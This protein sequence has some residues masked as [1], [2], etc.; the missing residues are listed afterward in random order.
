MADEIV[1]FSLDPNRNADGS[2][3]V[4]VV[5]QVMTD[6]NATGGRDF[7]SDD[8]TQLPKGNL[9]ITGRY[10][11][12]TSNMGG[13]R[14]DAFL[15]KVPYQWF[16]QQVSVAESD[17]GRSQ[18]HPEPDL[19]SSV[20]SA[21]M[22]ADGHSR[23]NSHVRPNRPGIDRHHNLGAIPRCA[24]APEAKPHHHSIPRERDEAK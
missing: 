23:Q 15:V 13:G 11:I 19:D 4:L 7:N 16:S 5:G 14:L 6:L 18:C 12:W 3:D 2:L 24:D 22:M 10:F 8:Y 21:D 20:W 9:D 17:F 1:C